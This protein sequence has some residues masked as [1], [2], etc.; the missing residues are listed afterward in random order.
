MTGYRH[1]ETNRWVSTEPSERV[2]RLW[3]K[4]DPSALFPQ[5]AS[6]AANPFKAS[7]VY[8]R[9]FRDKVASA[10]KEERDTEQVDPRMLHESFNQTHL[11][12]PAFEHYN[13]G[14]QGTFEKGGNVGNAR[15]VVFE[16]PDGIKH[17]MTGRHRA[18]VS[19]L[20]G[21]QFDAVVVRSK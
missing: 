8:D 2:Q 13:S 11:Y 12:K 5:G 16:D 1:P 19:L 15:P 3:G 6:L 17:I 21:R 14:E 4:G 7:Q 9:G 10:L 20:H 18:A